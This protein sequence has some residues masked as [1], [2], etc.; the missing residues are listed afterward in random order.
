[1]LWARKQFFTNNYSSE[2]HL[3]TSI[4]WQTIVMQANI[5]Y[6]NLLETL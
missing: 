1:M 6:K 4:I 3:K 5:F 2:L